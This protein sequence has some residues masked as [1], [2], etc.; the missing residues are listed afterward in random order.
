ML[1]QDVTIHANI[2]PISKFQLKEFSSINFL[3]DKDLIC[4]S[5]DG[6]IF[7]IDAQTYEIK[8]SLSLHSSWIS[9]VFLDDKYFVTGS[10]D[11]NI[12]LTYSEEIFDYSQ[13]PKFSKFSEHSDYILAVSICGNTLISSSSEPLILLSTINEKNVKSFR[14]IHLNN[15][16]HTIFSH[17]DGEIIFGT[18][19]GKLL[20]SKIDSSS[21]QAQIASFDAA[22]KVLSQN[23]SFFAAGFLDGSVLLFK[24]KNHDSNKGNK[25]VYQYIEKKK[26]ES[27]IVSI[28]PYNEKFVIFTANGNIYDLNVNK[29]ETIEI[30]KPISYG[31]VMPSNSFEQNNSTN[32]P[33]KTKN[34]QQKSSPLFHIATSDG[35]LFC[36]NSENEIINKID[37]DVS[38]T[39]AVRIPQTSTDILCKTSR[40]E[41]ILLN[42]KTLEVEKNF[43]YVSFKRKLKELSK[44]P[45]YSFPVSFDVSCGY[46]KIIIP[47]IL[48]K[49]IPNQMKKQREDLTDI[50]KKLIEKKVMI[51]ALDNKGKTIW[52][53]KANESVPYWFKYL[54][55]PKFT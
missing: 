17:S 29:F 37:N 15:S 28:C 54:L 34:S 33:K 10:Y 42:L 16:V 18:T 35:V 30:R 26:F 52:W 36:I 7:Q 51:F 22:T 38:Y 2:T 39:K 24:I 5:K 19:D 40:K 21:G 9:A 43:G 48:P 31:C 49:L 44:S 25:K 4:S 47:P 6:R 27:R 14:A 20:S 3:G 8:R 32:Q 46:V 13:E 12:M 55:D 45:S 41:V 1:C 23:S 11:M 53:S 50:I